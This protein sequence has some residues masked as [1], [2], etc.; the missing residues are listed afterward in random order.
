MKQN[1]RARIQSVLQRNSPANY[2]DPVD[3]KTFVILLVSWYTHEGLLKHEPSTRQRK[4]A[5]EK[6]KEQAA[7]E[8][9]HGGNQSSRCEDAG[10]TSPRTPVQ[11]QRQAIAK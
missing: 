3:Q 11:Q 10:E 2:A 6:M 5:K 7:R 8:H 1:G 9:G 4:R